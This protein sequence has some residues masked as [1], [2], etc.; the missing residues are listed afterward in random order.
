[1]NLRILASVA[2]AA[3]LATACGKDSHPSSAA[4]A[5]PGGVDRLNKLVRGE[6]SAVES[7]RQAIEK[8]GAPATELSDIKADHQDALEKLRARV[9]ALGGTPATDSGPWGD[10]AKA[11]EGSA[12][13]FGN[14]TAISALKAGEKMGVTA[15]EDALAD[16]SLDT[17][18]KDLIRNTLLTRQKG[19]EARLDRAKAQ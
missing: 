4:S 5:T 11:V 16:A 9:V 8:E 17:T 2:V 7:Y 12:K 1:M 3:L 10:F 19:H 6:M 18:S 14:A 15:Y 13:V